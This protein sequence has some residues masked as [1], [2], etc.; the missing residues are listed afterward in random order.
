MSLQIKDSYAT[1][2]EP[3]VHDKFVA[4]NLSTG[5]KLKEVDDYGRPKYANS[6]WRATF[7]GN[8]LAG[9]K[10]LKEKDRIKI[11]SG[12]ITHEKSDK[13]DANGNAR[14]FYNVTVF[15]FETV[16]SATAAASKPTDDNLDSEQPDLPF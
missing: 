15:D 16:A 9:A 13:T 11:V 2:F 12:T 8:A 1:I 3:E 7:V 14:Y 10:A 5:R 6:S 4:C